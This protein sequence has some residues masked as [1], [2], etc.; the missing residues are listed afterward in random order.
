MTR[1][2]RAWLGVIA[3]AVVVGT[4]ALAAWRTGVL[5]TDRILMPP[6]QTVRITLPERSGRLTLAFPSQGWL[7]P[8]RIRH[9][10]VDYAGQRTIDADLFPAPLDPRLGMALYWFPRQGRDGPYLRLGDPA[11]DVVLDLRGFAAWRV[12]TLAD[13]PWLVAPSGV[14]GAGVV[15]DAEG[16]VTVTAGRPFPAMAVDDAE[17]AVLLGRVVATPDGPAFRPAGESQP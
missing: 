10:S 6:P 16:R 4:A 2:T 17:T 3:L 14:A 1:R 7:A 13:Q 8:Y 5:R 9:V 12:S 15:T 11:G